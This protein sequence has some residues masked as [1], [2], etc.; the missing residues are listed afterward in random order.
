M[1]TI[2]SQRLKL[3][4]RLV[5]L[6]YRKKLDEHQKVALVALND[7]ENLAN[8]LVRILLTRGTSHEQMKEIRAW[9]EI[10]GYPIK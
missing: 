10:R 9:K 7:M 3:R 1:E 2:R 4:G 5:L 6:S 8:L